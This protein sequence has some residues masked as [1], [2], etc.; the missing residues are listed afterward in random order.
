[1]SIFP[2]TFIVSPPSVRVSL[3]DGDVEL[4][5]LWLRE[6]T[7]DPKATDPRTQQRLFDS[8][9]IDA[10]VTLAC[11]QY[12][13]DGQALITFSDGHQALYSSHEIWAQASDAKP[14]REVVGWKSDLQMAEVRHDWEKMDQDKHFGAALASY[15]RYRFIILNNVPNSREQVL[16][17]GSKFG[18]IK[19]TNFG[20]Y[21]EVYSKPEANDLA[22]RSVALGP[23]TDNPY[24]DP[25]PGIQL[26]HCLLN[27][28]SGGL[29]TLV[30]SVSVVQTLK[31]ED[32][33]GYELLKQTPVRFRFVDQGVELKTWRP[34]IS[35]DHEGNTLG[36]HYSPRLDSLPLLSHDDTVAF[37]RARQRLA[38]LFN[39]PEYELR[40]RLAAGEL[41]LFDNSRILHG[42]TGYDPSEGRRH[43]QGCYIDLDGPQERYSEVLKRLKITREVA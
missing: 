41:M 30:D 13:A 31:A 11:L 16:T 34:M 4:S 3:S 7:P 8:H 35:T 27:E 39:H 38:E 12:K 40:F 22:Y 24:R 9:R 5:A 42:R 17:V 29:S 15:L 25:V 10:G 20:R 32:P 1:M 19:E 26:L 23:H 6:H 37:H 21:F 28:T 18:Y 36:V 14:N 43:L 2:V 33:M